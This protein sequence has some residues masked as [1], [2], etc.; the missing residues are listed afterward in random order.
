MKYRSRM[1]IAALIL[2]IAQDGSLKT[3]IMYSA[4]LSFPQLNEYLDMLV[5]SGL[6]EYFQDDKEYMTTEKGKDFIEKYKETAAMIFP[7]KSLKHN[8]RAS[9]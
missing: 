5:D 9:R 3:R 8:Q 7:R 1:D 6:L 2:E 4:F